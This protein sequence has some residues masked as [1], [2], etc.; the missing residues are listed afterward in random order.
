MSD[1]K[2]VINTLDMLKTAYAPSIYKNHMEIA[3]QALEKQ[4]PKKP[5]KLT[6]KF[7]ID[8]GWKWECPVCKGAVG[9]NKNAIDYTQEDDYCPSCGQKLDWSDSE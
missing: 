2:K 6:Y 8:I 7:L 5:N 3:I 9:E 1:I 4:V